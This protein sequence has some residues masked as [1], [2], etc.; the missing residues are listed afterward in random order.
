MKI[1]IISGTLG[2]CFLTLILFLYNTIVLNFV[3]SLVCSLMVYEIFFATKMLEKSFLMF[4]VSVLYSVV[5]P[6]LNTWQFSDYFLLFTMVY[7][8][9][10]VLFLLKQSKRIRVYD[11]FFCCVFSICVTLFT[12][13]VIYIRQ[14][15]FPYG[16][17]Y[18]ILFFIIPWVCDAGAYF[19]GLRFGKKKLAPEISPKKTVEGA[20]GGA[21]FSLLSV[22]IYN[23]IF[24]N[25]INFKIRID[26]VILFV[27]TI[28]G[29]VFSIVGDL[30]M[31]VFK[32]QNNIKDFG[33]IIKGHG[34]ILDRFDSWLFVSAILYPFVKHFPIL[35]FN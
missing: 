7:V 22:L 13:N 24:L 20:I 27:V 33:N 21:I 8:I 31:S 2:I 1:R 26:F 19:M 30:C 5:I 14:R 3:V 16:L 17:Y 15:F 25:V 6:F 11:M 32:R 4:L 23:I 28:L 9:L 29:I 10:N 34:G 12:S 35:Y 18:V